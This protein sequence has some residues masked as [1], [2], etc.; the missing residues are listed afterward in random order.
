MS[1]FSDYGSARRGPWRLPK[2]APVAAAAMTGVSAAEYAGAVAPWL[3]CAVLAAAV[4]WFGMSARRP[5]LL[6]AVAAAFGLGHALER[7]GRQ[8]FPLRS[9]LEAGHRVE[10]TVVGVVAGEV[11]A[12]PTGVRFPLRLEEVRTASESW[13][14][15]HRVLVRWRGAA[16]AVACGDR[17]VV[18]G[19]LAAPDGPR[20]PGEFD[21][22]R[23]LRRQG[24]AGELRVERLARV[25][26]AAAL[27][28][29]R[30]ALRVREVLAR[31]ITGDLAGQ[32]EE[33]AVIRAMV[34]GA[35]E[36]AAGGVE[37]AFR[38]AGTLHIFSVSGLHVGLVA[39]ILWK[40]CNLVRLSRR[41]AAW[42]SIPL[43]L[44]YALVT[45][46]QPAAV[47][48]AFM[49]SV[50]LLGIGVNRPPAF[51]NSLCLAGVFLLA[52]DSHQ[53]FLPGAQLS[54]VVIAV[55]AG[56]SPPVAR[57]LG[58]RVHPDPFLPR[59]L[60]S[61]RWRWGQAAWLWL[62]QM[63][64]VSLVAAVGS[65]PLTLWHFQLV[66]PVSLVA[67]L[68]HVPLAGLILATAAL[69]A[70]ASLIGPG[71]AAVFTHANLVFA[72]VCLVTA[73]AFARVPGGAVLWNPR[74][75]TAAPG[76]C[77]VTVFDVGRGAATLIRTPRGRA[78]LI[79][80]GRPA[81]FRGSV[82]SGLAWHAVR[83][84]DGLILSHGDHEHIGGA[85]EAMNRLSPSLLGH[86]RPPSR[87][88]A[89]R[90]ALRRPEVEG[91]P[92]AAGTVL[93]LDE[94]TR[95]TVLWP[96]VGASLPLAD[97]GCLVLQLDCAGRRLLLSHDA[98]FLAERALARSHPEGRVD[99]W[100]RGSHASDISGLEESLTRLQPSLVVCAGCR[101]PG[102][103][104]V[105]VAWVRLAE[106]GGAQVFD[107]AETGAVEIVIHRDGRLES[108]PFLGASGDG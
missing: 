108:R 47:R 15:N 35:R 43:V 54:F 55:I 97:D 42:A 6:L 104:R 38:Y 64:A 86:P 90:D 22:A 36:E 89:L 66:T 52:A 57:W 105:P 68:V 9:H 50:V 93:D 32:P 71:A 39:V 74:D 29:R 37:E 12:G 65:A 67:N 3:W 20:N 4:A 84:L 19:W 2:L 30:T 13:L 62:A 26:A 99:V 95:L 78:W 45:G 59:V 56:G 49:A 44:F 76:T 91:R 79:D 85:I 63:L 60:W 80:T 46:W 94:E 27:P 82:A 10:V 5:A 58:H 23:W 107:Q 14:V 75:P 21:A 11:V 98:G 87:S 96:P 25:D 31:A 103:E 101:E 7:A 70:A 1:D 83:R 34:L 61:R 48:S 33:T 100:V 81:A 28:V 40:V 92:L 8:A 41:Q 53:L 18:S 69:S 73:D 106:A 16:A 51:F 77:R 17:V 88:P 72:R 102:V 24:M